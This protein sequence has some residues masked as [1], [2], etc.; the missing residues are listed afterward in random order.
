MHSVILSLYIWLTFLSILYAKANASQKY[1]VYIW[2]ISYF[3]PDIHPFKEGKQ[4]R[5]ELKIVDEELKQINRDEI[6]VVMKETSNYTNVY[7]KTITL[8]REIIG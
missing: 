2:K 7:N 5:V 3:T 8:S 1:T 4:H 6:T